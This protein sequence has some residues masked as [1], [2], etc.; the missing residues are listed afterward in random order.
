MKSVEGLQ[1][2][3]SPSPSSVTLMWP[4]IGGMLIY[5]FTTECYFTCAFPLLVLLIS[6]VEDRI[7]SPSS[8]NPSQPCISDQ[9]LPVCIY[10]IIDYFTLVR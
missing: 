8:T 1:F 10:I 9:C 3:S 5:E 6:Q 4:S 7:K 2:R